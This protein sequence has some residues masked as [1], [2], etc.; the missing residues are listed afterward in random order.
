MIQD[1]STR[2]RMKQ[3]FKRFRRAQVWAA[4]TIGVSQTTISRYLSGHVVSARLD[5][6][7]LLIAAELERTNGDC[8]DD[9]NGKSLRSQLAQIKREARR[10][11]S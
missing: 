4:Q 3:I 11:N 2:D 8:I 7:L 10:R 9:V 5:R 1:D 6:S